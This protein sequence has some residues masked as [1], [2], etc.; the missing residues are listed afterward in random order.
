LQIFSGPRDNNGLVHR[1]TKTGR[2][3]TTVGG[4]ELDLTSS[5]SKAK[6]HQPDLYD[7]DEEDED[8]FSRAVNTFYG[9]LGK[10]VDDN[11]SVIRVVIIVLAALAYNAYLVAVIKRASDSGAAIDWCDGPGFLFAVTAVVYAALFYFQVVKRFFGRAL[12]RAVVD[13]FS[14]T[15]DYVFSYR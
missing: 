3:E 9:R 6:L 14:A 1:G 12:K 2:D 10:A 15:V 5:P 11:W 4:L 7:S 8:C 13:P